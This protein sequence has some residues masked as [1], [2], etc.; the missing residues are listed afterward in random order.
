[1]GSSYCLQDGKDVAPSKLAKKAS[2]PGAGAQRACADPLA[3][4][5]TLLDHFTRQRQAGVYFSLQG[6]GACDLASPRA[7]RALDAPPALCL[8]MQVLA[9]E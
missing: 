5:Q 9:G 2:Q 3:D 4:P 7:R 6:R 1:M 8:L